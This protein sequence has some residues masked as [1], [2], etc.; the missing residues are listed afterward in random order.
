MRAGGVAALSAPCGALS[1]KGGRTNRL[2]Q[3]LAA[4]MLSSPFGAA[5]TL[6][7]IPPTPPVASNS[8]PPLLQLG[9]VASWVVAP[10]S[11][12][13]YRSPRPPPR[14]SPRRRGTPG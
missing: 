7:P 5:D 8:R 6:P 2:A 14:S 1:P 9:L 12:S 11:R 10:L 3:A 4:H 13:A